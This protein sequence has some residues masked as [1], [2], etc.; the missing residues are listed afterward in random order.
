MEPRQHEKKI[1][2][3][4]LVRTCDMFSQPILKCSKGFIWIGC[5]SFLERRNLW[6]SRDVWEISDSRFSS[7]QE[8]S[9]S[10]RKSAL[11]WKLCQKRCPLMVSL[12]DVKNLDV[13]MCKNY[14]GLFRTVCSVYNSASIL[15]T[16]WQ[17]V[18]DKKSWQ[19]WL[20]EQNSRMIFLAEKC[21]STNMIVFND[22]GFLL[23]AYFRCV[24]RWWR[25]Q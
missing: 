13:F 15:S 10:R 16:L 5:G 2:H 18:F 20:V 8:R 7:W 3:V 25:K 19:L 21:L 22:T 6:I 11:C 9:G 12:V 23:F 14:C 4:F 1:A 17:I 24:Y